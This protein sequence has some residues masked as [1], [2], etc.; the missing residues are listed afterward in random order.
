MAEQDNSILVYEIPGREKLIDVNAKDKD[1]FLSKFPNAKLQNAPKN[2]DEPK[3]PLPNKYENSELL[4]SVTTFDNLEQQSKQNKNEKEVVEELPSV[5]TDITRRNERRAVKMLTDQYSKFGF[6]FEQA[7]VGRDVVRIIANKDQDNEVSKEFKIDKWTLA[8]DEEVAKQ[9]TEFMNTHKINVNRDLVNQELNNARRGTHDDEIKDEV[10]NSV[11]KIYQDAEKYASDLEEWTSQY[12]DVDEI[13]TNVYENNRMVEKTLKKPKPPVDNQLYKQAIQSSAVENYVREKRKDDKDFEVD[14]EKI[15]NANDFQPFL[16]EATKKSNDFRKQRVD[17]NNQL[18]N[19]SIT[20]EQYNNAIKSL[21][22]QGDI[23]DDFQNS[24]KSQLKSEIFNNNVM[25]DQKDLSDEQ[26]NIRKEISEDILSDV[27]TEVEV[28]TKTLK[29]IADAYTK[30]EQMMIDNKAESEALLKQF[31]DIKNGKYTTQEE[32]DEANAKLTKLRDQL[33]DKQ[34]KQDYLFK[35]MQEYGELDSKTRAELDELD[36]NASEIGL[37]SKEANRIY[38]AYGLRSV[39]MSFPDFAV[40]LVDAVDMAVEGKEELINSIDDPNT[41][42]AVKFFTNA[43][44][45]YAAPVTNLVFSDVVK[46]EG[47]DERVSLWDITREKYTGLKESFDSRVKIPPKWEDLKDGSDYAEYFASQAVSQAPILATLAVTGGLPGLAIISASSIGGKYRQMQDER[48]LYK[49]TGGIYGMNH[50]FGSMALNATLSGAA[51][52]ALEYTTGKILGATARSL[53]GPISQQ[54]INTG[55]KS[56]LSSILTTAGRTTIGLG[57]EMLEEGVAEGLSAVVGNFADKYI[58]GKDEVGLF[59]GVDE[60]FINGAVLAAAMQSP[61]LIGPITRPFLSKNSSDRVAKIGVEIGDLTKRITELKN[62]GDP[63]NLELIEKLENQYVELVDES[64]RL[65]EQDIKRVDLLHPTEKRALVEID[66]RNYLDN[67]E[68]DNIKKDPELS[69]DD[70]A[71]KIQEVQNRIDSRNN[72]KQAIISKY[73]PN[74]VDKN[75]EKQINTLK[76]MASMAAEYGAPVVNIIETDREGFSER[77]SRY[78]QNMSKAQVENI[79]SEN[80]GM[81]EGLNEIINDPNSTDSEVENARELLKDAESQVKIA[82]NLLAADDY[83]VMQPKFDNKGN[84]TGIDIIVN[85]ETAITDGMLNTPAH[86]FIH[87]TF[88]NTLKAD[89]AMRKILGN[90]LKTILEGKGVTFSSTAKLNEFNKRIAAYNPDQQGEEMMAIASEMMF[91]GDIKFNDNVLQKLA[92][93]YRRFTQKYLGR[94][95][96]F[97]TTEDIKN[98]MRDYHYSI[99]N[100]KPS[101]AIAKMLAKGANGKVF[102]DARTPQERKRQ[103]LHNKSVQQNM[104][105]DPDLMATYDKYTKNADGTPKYKTQEDFESSPDFYDAYFEILQGKK[106]DRLIQ[107]GMTE[108]GLPAEA[109]IDFTRKVKER[110]ADR[111]LPKRIEDR[112]GNPILDENGL[113]QFKPGYRISNPSL[114]GWLTGVAGG[115]GKSVIYRAKGD[116]MKQYKKEGGS[117][118]RSLDRQVSEDGGTIADTVAD[119]K[120]TL[121]TDIDNADMTP[122]LKRDLKQTVDDVLFVTDIIDLPQDNRSTISETVQQAQNADLMNSLTDPKSKFSAI[123]NIKNLVVD[124]DFDPDVV[125]PKTKKPLKTEK[126]AIPTGPYF[127]V[128]NAV[129]SYMGIDPLRILARQDL[130]TEQ[131]NAA[132]KLIYDISVDDSGQLKPEILSIFGDQGATTGGKATGLVGKTFISFYNKGARARK[133]DTGSGITTLKLRSDITK[134]EF[135]DKFGINENGSLQPGTKADGAIRE[136]AV[137]LATLSAVQETKLNA[138]KNQVV[139]SEISNRLRDGSPEKLYN[140]KVKNIDSDTIQKLSETSDVRMS[141]IDGTAF[142]L[143]AETGEVVNLG[144]K[145]EK[146]KRKPMYFIDLTAPSQYE[147]G[148]TQGEHIKLGFK[149]FLKNNPQFRQII[150]NT[151]VFGMERSMYGT[152]DNFDNEYPPNDQDQAV[153]KRVQVV[154]GKKQKPKKIKELY[155]TDFKAREQLLYDFHKAIEKHLKTRP[156]DFVVMNELL[157]NTTNNQGGAYN[158]V[159]VPYLFHGINSDGTTD[160]ETL[161]DEEHGS[162]ARLVGNLYMNASK[163]GLVDQVRPIIKAILVQGSLS[164]A[165]HAI[166]N[167]NYK[168]SFPQVFYDKI[169]PA[170]RDGKL[171]NIDDGLISFIRYAVPHTM[172]DGSVEYIN[173]NKLKWMPTGKTITEQFGVGFVGNPSQQTIKLQNELIVKVLSGASIETIEQAKSEFNKNKQ[174]NDQQLEMDRNQLDRSNAVKTQ[175][176]L[177]ENTK[178]LKSKNKV[179]VKGMSTFDFDETLIIDGENFVIATNP[180]TGEQTRISSGDWPVQGPE[181]ADMGYEFNFD[182]FVNVRGGVD[183]PLLQKMKN[184][185]AKYGADNVFILTARPQAAASAINGWLKSKGID[186]PFENITGLADSRG[187]AKAQWMLDKF[188]EGYN[189]MYFVDDALQNV[190]AVKNVLDQLDI[191]SKVVQAK[192]KQVN[193]LVDTS[194]KMSSKV[195]EPDADS[196]IDKEFNKIIEETTGVDSSR[197]FSQAEGRVRGR[198]I[199]RSITR[200]FKDFFIPPSAEDFKGLMYKLLGKGKVGDR[201]FVWMKEKLFE[202]YAKGIRAWNTYKQTMAN[203]Y[204]ALR[205]RMPNVKLRDQV[206]GT[207]YTVDT[208]IRAYLWNKAGYN[209]PGLSESELQILLDK[210][211][212]NPDLLTYAESLQQITR[213]EGYIEPGPNW[214]VSTIAGDLN[215]IVGSVGRQQFLQDF[216]ANKDIIFSPE[217][218]AKLEAIYGPDYVNALEDMLYRMENG[219]NRNFGKDKNVNRLLRWING[220]VGAVMFF[221]IRSA[222]L[223]T[224]S[225]VNFIN[226]SDNNMFAAAKAF[227]NQPQFWKDFAMIFNSDMLKQRRAGLEID[228]NANE[229]TSVF[230]ERGYSPSTVIA[231][232]LEKGFA[233]T[234]IADSFA[235]AMGGASFYR[236]RY[237]KLIKDGMSPKQAA[238]QAFLDFQEVA[239]ETQQSSRPDLISQQQAGTLGRLILAWQNTPMQMTRLLKKALSDAANGRGDMKTNISKILY[240]GF[241]Q[242]VWFGA[243]QSGLA[244]LLFGND[245]EEDGDDVNRKVERVMNGALDTILRGTGI[246]GAMLST[247]KNTLIQWHKQRQKGFGQRDD[248]RI[249]LEAVSLSPPIGSKLRKIYNAIKTEQFNQG[250]G[251]EIGYRVE[252]PNLSIFANWVEA[253]TNLPLARLVNKANNIEEAVT[254]NHEL[255]QRVALIAGWN[256]WDIGIEDEELEEAKEDAKEQR[257]KDKKEEKEQEKIQEQKEKEAKGIKTVQCSGIRSNGERCKITG[258]TTEKKFLCVHHRSFVEGSDTDGDG[259]KEYRCT[260]IKSNGE[261]CKNKTE[262][263]NKK[264]YAHQ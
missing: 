221:N 149:T 112:N 178:K 230:K 264:C 220:S 206:D 253:L 62:S 146:D 3:K 22:E 75:Y 166:V 193:R 41:R 170:L 65:V 1:L 216:S 44:L 130:S 201:Q 46:K 42:K 111:F 137:V 148:L 175:N 50:S 15:I 136:L 99:A 231:F 210:V 18:Q 171:K 28:K 43:A 116:I 16:D 24:V 102:E 71:K 124:K 38:E 96:K 135:L 108:L 200:K 39:L 204:Q 117:D 159:L 19:G 243:M 14:Y 60:A 55:V 239:E 114:F 93:V 182:D 151:T 224:I 228:V 122:T 214:M 26:K 90:Q 95:I 217:N 129:A 37:Y 232:L 83:G 118:R 77:E 249:L 138:V 123:K 9:M 61:R 70:R 66:K 120:D 84:L 23:H 81:V 188:A 145:V 68:I 40:N 132:K 225:T 8:Q 5:T 126:S 155:E 244:F 215:S 33:I 53:F 74:V 183:G 100:N 192:L 80:I 157:A 140:R 103:R 52:G 181:F 142:Y 127:N 29:G 82:D 194:D 179:D 207:A 160:T 198:V 107:S 154:E 222:M 197:R 91:D 250:V 98:F 51:E 229:L 110:I 255:W 72:R 234:R 141:Q 245:D 161:F 208:A 248:G 57:N 173:L 259:K 153:E 13:V 32:V 106:L 236:N 104:D 187:E 237:N 89:P 56:T 251:K 125:N 58:S 242:N 86:E 150:K 165:D 199:E 156:Q 69:K 202:P 168:S 162:P 203:E 36:L 189:D 144:F 27:R 238:D 167:K 169:L 131:R 263:A 25:E 94:D 190:D 262:N 63:K 134:A 48:E 176:I 17:L 212:N 191:K 35:T 152:V 133:T 115:A 260:A 233:P 241:I 254:G 218:L 45:T 186:I 172:K 247:L 158:R 184:Q 164:K 11:N 54:A 31:N 101:K 163:L 20:Q 226:W 211:N 67:K 113:E 185:I 257:K 6:D 246:Y 261:R 209:I 147:Q 2:E 34:Q 196:T 235:I 7:S 219:T 85:K 213:T 88:A 252:N 180:L 12:G 128:L 143:D 59:D 87:A 21:N 10:N 30:G 47:E 92:G 139:G 105:S 64:N 240:Y 73:P 195:I 109:L 4:P 256:K 227:A 205:K 177:Q 223:Q 119:K 78:D 76:R 79:A 97:D 174:F 121:M 49:Q 258:E